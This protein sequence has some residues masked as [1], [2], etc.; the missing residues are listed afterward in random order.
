MT[1]GFLLEL[2]ELIS[3]SINYMNVR[4]VLN[5]KRTLTCPGHGVYLYHA[6]PCAF[7][8]LRCV[9]GQLFRFLV[10]A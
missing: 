10:G 5:Q 9:S 8:V 1:S 7:S 4:Y 3:N 2:R 6:F